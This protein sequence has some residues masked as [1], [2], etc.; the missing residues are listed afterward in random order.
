MET[1]CEICPNY[2]VILVFRRVCAFERNVIAKWNSETAHIHDAIKCRSSQQ[3]WI[4]HNMSMKNMQKDFVCHRNRKNILI[5]AIEASKFQLLYF[6]D[7]WF[8]ESILTENKIFRIFLVSETIHCLNYSNLCNSFEETEM[9]MFACLLT[10]V[11][12][13]IT[14]TVH[15]KNYFVK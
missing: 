4:W 7:V 9:V 8:S 11:Y 3:S 6:L 1:L 5:V 12:L 14:V 15:W 2:C 13:H 10:T